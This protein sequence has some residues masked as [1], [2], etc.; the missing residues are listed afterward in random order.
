MNYEMHVADFFFFS[1]P[2]LP[3]VT[4]DTGDFRS[5]AGLFLVKAL[6][7]GNLLYNAF[8]AKLSHITQR[9]WQRQKE[10]GEKKKR[11]KKNEKKK[12]LQMAK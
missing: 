11:E 9:A 6:I 10:G 2:S 4:A 12:D 3:R 7:S 8:Y 1:F 5:S